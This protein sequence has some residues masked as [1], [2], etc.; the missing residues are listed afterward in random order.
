[1]KRAFL[2]ILLLPLFLYGNYG[3]VFLSEEYDASVLR[4]MGIKVL[5]SSKSSAICQLVPDNMKTLYESGLQF[6]ILSPTVYRMIDKRE[7]ETFYI[8]D[9]EYPPYG[10]PSSIAEISVTTAYM[11]D[12]STRVRVSIYKETTS[13]WQWVTHVDDTVSGASFF[14]FNIDYQLPSEYGAYVYEAR[15]LYMSPG[16]WVRTDSRQYF[17]NVPTP[18]THQDIALV[19]ESSI[20]P[21]IMNEITQYRAYVET[22]YDVTLHIYE[23]SWDT[24]EE[25]RPYISSLASDSGIAGIVLVGLFPYAMWEFPWGETCPI[26]FFYEDLDG[27]FLDRDGDG[28]YDW[29]EFGDEP[30]I[31][32]WV[33]WMRPPQNNPSSLLEFLQKCNEYYDG[34]I[35]IPQRG[36]ACINHDW[37]G[38]MKYI[39]KSIAQIYGEEVDTVGGNNWYVAGYEYLDH[40]TRGYEITNIWAHSSSYFHNFDRPP[41]WVFYNEL[42]DTYPGSRFTSLFACHGA[43]FHESPSNNLAINYCFGHATGL[44]SFGVTRSMGTGTQDILFNSLAYG[45][46]LGRAYL[47]YLNYHCDPQRISYWFPSDTLECFMWDFAFI[48]N[49]FVTFPSPYASPPLPPQDVDASPSHMSIQLGWRDNWETDLIGYNVYR[50][51]GASGTYEMINDSIIPEAGLIDTLIDSGV[52]YYYVVTAVDS[53]GLESEYSNPDSALPMSFDEGILLVDETWD[54]PG[55]PGN[56][57][58][59]MVDEFYRD[60]FSE[61][62]LDFDEWDVDSQGTPEISTIGRYSLIVWYADHYVQPLA[63]NFVPSLTRYLDAGGKLWFIGW[64]PVLDIVGSGTYPFTFGDGDFLFDYLGCDTAYESFSYEFIGASGLSG[65]PDIDIDTS[66]IPSSWDGMMYIDVFSGEDAVYSF[67]SLNQESEYQGRPCALRCINDDY[68]A[69]FFGFPLYFTNATQ[70]LVSKVLE[71]LGELGIEEETVRISNQ[72]YRCI[73]NPFIVATNISFSIARESDVSLSVYDVMGRRV[74]TIL[75][76]RLKKGSHTLSFNGQALPQGVYFIH[77]KIGGERFKE[78]IVKLGR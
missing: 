23:G 3:L 75:E 65:Y 77:L 54:G 72:L 56:P 30:L 62:N 25:M 29:H 9:I 46:D 5:S 6:Q 14:T 1:M 49:P 47:D 27:I 11:F 74:E 31:D 33:C 70:I 37:F 53:D 61:I 50:K 32:I 34:G 48:G 45:K 10:S 51:E 36:F 4:S 58:D 2:Y 67:Q 52:W 15:V 68:K 59:N 17:I 21:L 73:P 55:N 71:D 42:R 39:K 18:I 20:A 57:T 22:D 13:G 60:L 64:R 7:K 43:D 38:A 26:P 63:S 28:F 41:N 24:A 66:K 35:S 44:A 12:D 76:D 19:L 16:G 40:L 8:W 78:K 69:I